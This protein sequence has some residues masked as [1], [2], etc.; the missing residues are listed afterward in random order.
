MVEIKIH[1]NVLMEFLKEY[2]KYQ[3]YGWTLKKNKVRWNSL[4]M[5]LRQSIYAKLKRELGESKY[6]VNVCLY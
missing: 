1:L 3:I 6:E 4:Q 2:E 5:K